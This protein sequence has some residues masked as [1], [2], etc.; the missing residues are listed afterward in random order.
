MV[1]GKAVRWSIR[2]AVLVAALLAGIAPWLARSAYAC[3][4]VPTFN[5]VSDS[6][7]IVAG[8]ILDWQ[9]TGEMGSAFS[10]PIRLRLTVDQVFKGTLG[11]D[12]IIVQS[13]SL[14]Q[15]GM[16]LGLC[17]TFHADPAG[18]YVVI[19][20]RRSADGTYGQIGFTLFSIGAETGSA[21]YQQAI[22]RLLHNGESAL[23]LADPRPCIPAADE[24]ACTPARGA[25]WDGDASAWAAEGVLDTDARLSATLALRSAAGDPATLAAFARAMHQPYVQVRRVRYVAESVPIVSIVRTEPLEF[26]ELVDLGGADQNLA[27]WTLHSADRGVIVELPAGRILK[28]GERCRISQASSGPPRCGV[29][30]QENDV[31]PDEGGR[32]LLVDAFGV[33][34]ADLRYSADPYNQ[35]PPPNL[36]GVRL[37][38]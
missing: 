5:P 12:L 32:V 35:P 10:V 14:Q 25:L 23:N 11:D 3:T 4:P 18:K 7:V 17:D 26:V 24:T 13:F 1:R 29:T 30:L 19:G 34:R 38:R 21:A 9:R 31:W 22:D 8:R 6:D 36:E 27:G 37:P 15:N 28:P 20:L 33:V 16:W 2:L